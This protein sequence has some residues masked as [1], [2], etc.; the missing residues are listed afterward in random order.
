VTSLIFSQSNYPLKTVI[1]GD[2]VVILTVKQAD[3]INNIFERQKA[4]IAGFKKDIIT[5]DS[6]IAVLDTIILEKEKVIIE[7]VFDDEISQRLDLLEA[8]LLDASINN[9]WIYYSW[10]DSTI[11]AVDL[12]Q[13]YVQKD[14]MT[15]DLYFYKCPTPIDPYEN[16]ENP[17]KGWERAIVK[18]ERPKVTKVPI[19]M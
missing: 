4:I 8:W 11:Y 7:H 13:Y 2:S 17:L 19:K 1:K 6:I 14:N 18:P 12:K 16:K 3:D 9:A 15:G 5:R 10:D